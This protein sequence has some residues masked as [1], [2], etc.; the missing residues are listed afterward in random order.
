MIVLKGI[1]QL[2]C[3]SYGNR[4]VKIPNLLFYVV[5]GQYLSRFSDLLEPYHYQITI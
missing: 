1:V 5:Q 2:F 3:S 4:V